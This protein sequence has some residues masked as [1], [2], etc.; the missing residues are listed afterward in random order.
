MKHTT[1]DPQ[2]AVVRGSASAAPRNTLPSYHL[3]DG[4]EGGIRPGLFARSRLV[5][6]HP[7]PSVKTAGAGRDET[8][9]YQT[10]VA[11]R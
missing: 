10:A 6:F 5:P 11:R 7:F 1:E 3:I 2:L 4:A 8:S 9:S